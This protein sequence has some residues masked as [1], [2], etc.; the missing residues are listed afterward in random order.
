MAETDVSEIPCVDMD[1]IWRS[2]G[3]KGD[4]AVC[5]RSEVWCHYSWPV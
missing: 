4:D 3:L 2:I 5:T 1:A